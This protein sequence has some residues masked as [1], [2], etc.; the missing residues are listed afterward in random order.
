M[1]RHDE[2]EERSVS[3]PTSTNA[4]SPVAAPEHQDLDDDE[5][6]EDDDK[7]AYQQHGAYNTFSVRQPLKNELRG[8]LV[9]PYVCPACDQTFSRPHNLKSHLATHSN[10]RP[11]KCTTCLQHFR[12]LHD[13]KRHEKL[14]TGEKPYVCEQCSRSFSRLDALNR[15]RRSE[16]AARRFSEG[17]ATQRSILPK[18]DNP[19]LPK[20]QFSSPA[21]TSASDA[22]SSSSSSSSLASQQQPLAQP[23]TQQQQSPNANNANNANN[24]SN[25]SNNVNHSTNS[26]APGPSTLALSPLLMANGSPE[27]T[28]RRKNSHDSNVSEDASEDAVATK[29]MK[30]Q[31][32]VFRTSR[33]KIP[34]I[35]IPASANAT[36]WHPSPLG[37]HPKPLQPSTTILAGELPTPNTAPPKSASSPRTDPLPSIP[38]IPATMPM[39]QIPSPAMPRPHHSSSPSTNASSTPLS[40][41]PHPTIHHPLH[42][43]SASTTTILPAIHHTNPISKRHHEP[44]TPLASPATP[45]NGPPPP[46]HAAHAQLLQQYRALEQKVDAMQQTIHDL[47]VENRVLRSLVLDRPGGQRPGEQP[48]PQQ[49]QA[50]HQGQ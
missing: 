19:L 12:R 37:Q 9:K 18:P 8:T 29:R 49:Q 15:H 25:S 40:P 26:S 35:N 22:S 43:A 1:P 28:K 42:P 13:L 44:S 23:S 46:S 36:T 50:Q 5:D 6:D 11:F 27:K 31:Q 14:H 3:P 4:C 32:H 45:A 10:V 38:S 39:P 20:R 16:Q 47:E 21:S 34:Q 30:S 7:P 24:A 2:P 41:H 17:D 48:Q 33:P